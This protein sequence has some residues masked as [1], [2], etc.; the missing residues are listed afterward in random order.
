MRIHVLTINGVFDTGLAAVLDA[1]NVGNALAEMTG[2]SSLR[3]ETTVVGLRKNITTGQGMT[4]PTALA[5]RVEAPDV[6]ILPAINRITPEPLEQALAGE[7]VR[8]A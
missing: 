1:F 2:V 5:A 7:D 6:V 3:F 4:M 8:Q